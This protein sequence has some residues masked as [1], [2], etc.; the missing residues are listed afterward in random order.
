[1][2]SLSKTDPD[3]CLFI[4]EDSKSAEIVKT[5]LSDMK[6]ASAKVSDKNVSCA[7]DYQLCFID[8]DVFD[9]TTETKIAVDNNKAE[10][11]FGDTDQET[12][13]GDQCAVG[14]T[15]HCH[16]TDESAS[17]ERI[18]MFDEMAGGGG[19]AQEDLAYI[20]LCE[21]F[22]NELKYRTIFESTHAYKKDSHGEPSQ[23]IVRS[24]KSESGEVDMLFKKKCIFEEGGGYSG[25]LY[26]W[27]PDW[28]HTY[29]NMY[30]RFCEAIL[31][32]VSD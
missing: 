24:V 29:S 10:F 7:R 16:H 3:N 8:D 17:D 12:S 19:C 20:V 22:V 18:I 28:L 23:Q 25:D 21:N 15:V 11:G 26:G 1:M 4:S 6:S 14:P 31:L 2:P 30:K 13:C 5:G 9:E 32:I 27:D